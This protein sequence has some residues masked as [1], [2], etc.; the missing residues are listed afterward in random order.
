MR[1]ETQ[2]TSSC[3]RQSPIQSVVLIV[4]HLYV[5]KW[6]VGNGLFGIGAFGAADHGVFVLPCCPVAVPVV[7]PRLPISP[8]NDP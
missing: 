4:P 7:I 3:R 1:V 5:Y 6:R 8:N 2:T